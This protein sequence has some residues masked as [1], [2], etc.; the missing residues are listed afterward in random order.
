MLLKKIL[1]RI[2][3]IKWN[4]SDKGE[5]QGR[6]P[7]LVVKEPIHQNRAGC[8]IRT[9]QKKRPQ[10]ISFKIADMTERFL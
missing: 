5:K 2:Q 7:T 6:K 4:G 3:R 10:K 1:N 8:R 9:E